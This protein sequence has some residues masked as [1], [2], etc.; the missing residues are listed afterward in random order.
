MPIDIHI[1]NSTGILDQELSEIRS[2]FM[3]VKLKAEEFLQLENADIV[4]SHNPPNAIKELGVGGYT[5]SVNS[6]IYISLDKHKRASL[7][8]IVAC[9]H[10]E[11]YHL[12]RHQLLGVP[13]TLQE[14]AIDEGLACLYEFEVTGK[15]PIYARQK[16]AIKDIKEFSR[17]LKDKRDTNKWFFGETGIQKWLGYSLGFNLVNN[18]SQH[19]HTSAPEILR[20]KSTTIYRE[21]S[22]L[23]G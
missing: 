22:S 1:L 20:I 15:I 12:R 6:T 4:V 7:P 14:R 3:T 16:V 8:A 19:Y 18:Y 2:A 10:H 23:P 17:H 13:I 21:S 9:M 5:D 11:L